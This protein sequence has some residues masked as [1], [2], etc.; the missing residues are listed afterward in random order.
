MRFSLALPPFEGS[1]VSLSVLKIPAH[2]HSTQANICY[3]QVFSLSI[4][5]GPDKISFEQ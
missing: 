4:E 2:N 5:H 1:S 3:C